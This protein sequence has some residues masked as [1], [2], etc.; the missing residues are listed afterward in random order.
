MQTVESK[1]Y[2]VIDYRLDGAVAVK[3]FREFYI[4]DDFFHAGFYYA[5]ENVGRK[6]QRSR[7][8]HVVGTPYRLNARFLD[9]D[10]RIRRPI[11]IYVENIFYQFY[12]VVQSVRKIIQ[13]H[14]P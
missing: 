1:L 13:S 4:I 5:S 3:Q 10:G 7:E 8:R 12:V 9:F 14:A 11:R 6:H 2:Q